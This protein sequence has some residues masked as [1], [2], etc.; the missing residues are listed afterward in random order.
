MDKTHESGYE[1]GCNNPNLRF[2]KIFFFE[3]TIIQ[4]EDNIQAIFLQ[5][6]EKPIER[7]TYCK[8]RTFHIKVIAL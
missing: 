4:Q 7:Y 1:S 8:K 3:K 5:K 2:A 6:R